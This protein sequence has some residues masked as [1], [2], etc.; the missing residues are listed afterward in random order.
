MQSCGALPEGQLPHQRGKV[1]WCEQAELEVLL[2]YHVECPVGNKA[3]SR[4]Y[5]PGIHFGSQIRNPGY[6][7]QLSAF[8]LFHGN[9]GCRAGSSGGGAGTEKKREWQGSDTP[10]PPSPSCGTR[11]GVYS[12]GTERAAVPRGPAL[13]AHSL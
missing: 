6:P 4:G 8:D 2:R 13:L 12:K 5:R 11:G 10:G 3:R 9:L 1:G 7:I